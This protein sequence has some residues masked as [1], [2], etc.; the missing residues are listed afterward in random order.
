MLLPTASTGQSGG[1]QFILRQQPTQPQVLT[2]QAPT[3]ATAIGS[4]S[5]QA[6]AAKS[7]VRYVSQMPQMA[8]VYKATIF[9]FQI[10]MAL[11][12]N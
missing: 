5:A 2:I 11:V 3:G 9:N 10:K 4:Q 7:I 8:Q 6:N 1:L 12:L